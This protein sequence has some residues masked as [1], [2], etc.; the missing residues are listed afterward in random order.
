MDEFRNEIFDLVE[1]FAQAQRAAYGQELFRA[2]GQE[3]SAGERKPVRS[4][5][6]P[7][8]GEF[9]CDTSSSRD[10]KSGDAASGLPAGDAVLHDNQR[11]EQRDNQPG[12]SCDPQV[13]GRSVCDAQEGGAERLSGSRPLERPAEEVRNLEPIKEVVGGPPR[14]QSQR[15]LGEQ[16]VKHFLPSL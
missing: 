16:A 15:S 8:C 9:T 2:E 6:G 12:H 14:E 7:G 4:N 3:G 10:V 13:S 11:E 1:R 5:H